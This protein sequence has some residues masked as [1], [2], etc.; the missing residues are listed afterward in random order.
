MLQFVFDHT[1]VDHSVCI[2]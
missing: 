1:C 2:F